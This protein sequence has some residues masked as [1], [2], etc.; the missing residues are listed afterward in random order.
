LEKLG[1]QGERPLGND[2]VAGVETGGDFDETLAVGAEL[3]FA[4]LEAVG[5][6]FHEDNALPLDSLD[7][8]R[9]YSHSLASGSG[10]NLDLGEHVQLEQPS[11]IRNLAPHRR[12]TG[13]RVQEIAHVGNNAGKPLPWVRRGGD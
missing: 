4:R 9:G 13:F 11:R 3:Y 2:R 6:S 5:A 10:Q 1:L 7:R 8:S 12:R